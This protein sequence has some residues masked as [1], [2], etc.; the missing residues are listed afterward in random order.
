[1]NVVQFKFFVHSI[2][3]FKLRFNMTDNNYCCRGEDACSV[4]VE[5][6]LEILH[7]RCSEKIDGK[8][9]CCISGEHG[10]GKTT[11]AAKFPVCWHQ[12]S[13][14]IKGVSTYDY[15]IPVSG[16]AVDLTSIDKWVGSSK[17]AKN[18]LSNFI[19]SYWSVVEAFLPRCCAKYGVK[20]VGQLLTT[21]K[22]LLI[23]DDADDISDAK[24]KELI[25]F[26]G[27][28]IYESSVLIFGNLESINKIKL[29]FIS[30]SSVQHFHL[31]GI[32]VNALLEIANDFKETVKT[33]KK[34]VLKSFK[35][36]IKGNMNRFVQFFEYPD[37]FKEIFS[38]WKSKSRLVKETFS[39]S[40][41]CWNLLL[42]KSNTAFQINLDKN[43][44]KKRKWFMWILLVGEM[45]HYCMRANIKLNEASFIEIKQSAEKLFPADEA[46][47]IVAEFFKPRLVFNSNSFQ[48]IP[49]SVHR[50]QLE[51]FSSY[52]VANKMK[53]EATLLIKDFLPKVKIEDFICL[54]G[55][56]L[57][58]WDTADTSDGITEEVDIEVYR[59]IITDL[60]TN[61]QNKIE[62]IQFFLKMATEF[63]C[64]HK[65]VQLMVNVTEYPEEWDL[66][67]CLLQQRSL[68]V[69]LQHVAPVRIILRTDETTQNYEQLSVLKFLAQV[70][71][72]VWF[73]SKDQFK[74]SSKKTMD[75][76]V[77]PFFSDKTMSRV[78]LLSGCLSKCSLLD[79]ADFKC[80]S[81]I[82]MLALKVNDETTL[83]TAV[84][85]PAHLPHIL[86][87]EL[88]IDMPI[89]NINL[90]SLPN[91]EVEM[92][93]VYLRDLDD[94]TIPR[95]TGLLTKLHKRYSGIHLDR[96]TLSPESIYTLLK[97]LKQRHIALCATPKS[98][99]KYR[100]W[101][102]PLLS[103]LPTDKLL[104]NK[105][106]KKILGFEDRRFY[107]DHMIISS[108]FVKSI[109]AWNLTSYLEELKEIKYFVYEADNISFTKTLKGEVHTEHRSAIHV[110][111]TGTIL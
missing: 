81:Y 36:A 89:D 79:L 31:H 108:T 21:K 20:T 59:R 9:I 40:E 91:M 98:I 54:V 103:N 58:R 4:P 28:I 50:P 69:L 61:D 23:I 18:D 80:M 72:S 60:V 22:V 29:N 19:D 63:H 87:F 39:T 55:G 94:L 46:E 13:E 101:Y 32:S 62:D 34:K 90:T 56:H 15:V 38:M 111:T 35:D 17:S 95:V 77:R 73:E 37:F 42:F 78:D 44:L 110:D 43:L 97:N 100:R 109:D 106:V 93:D 16:K 27:Q 11:L 48:S 64:S 65:L 99:D 67:L 105:D 84:G 52:Y 86:W 83:Q 66:K 74:Y 75:K 1:M 47:R 24:L 107:S 10:T 70:P 85:L 76:Y 25:L 102:Y 57:W 71:I 7:R 3:N 51:Y 12:Q 104:E 2:N 26:L 45:S 49:C 68:E 53:D 33:G 88:K 14:A 41:L 5:E 92:L 96:T 82:V 8:Q 6:I 30:F